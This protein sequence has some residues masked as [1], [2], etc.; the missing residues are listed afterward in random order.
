MTARGDVLIA[1]DPRPGARAQIKME[2]DSLK[3]P[4]QPP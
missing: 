1:V 4:Q 3:K 2:L